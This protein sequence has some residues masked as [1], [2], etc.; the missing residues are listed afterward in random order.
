MKT[1]QVSDEI[2][3][4]LMTFV[5]DPFEDTAESVIARLV[6][7]GDKARQQYGRLE[8]RRSDRGTYCGPERRGGGND[9]SVRE[10]TRIPNIPIEGPEVIL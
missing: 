2:Y 4:K 8:A 10:R 3:Q 6:E 1:L 7:I 5:V 9:E